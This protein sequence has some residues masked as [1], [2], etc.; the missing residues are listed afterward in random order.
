MSKIPVGQTIRFAYT[1]TFGE[2]GTIIGLIWIP[3]LINA[4]A[5]F[6]ALRAYYATLAD[7]FESGM[8]P[9]GAGLGLP[10]L[11][12]F[13]AMLMVAMIGVSITQQ[14][15]GLRQGPA[16]AHISLGSMEWRAFGG[17]FGLY[18]LFV[19]FI[20]IFALM[21]GATAAAS[22]TAVQSNPG[23]AAAAGVG[24]V[25]AVALGICLVAYMVVRL[26]FLLVPSVVDG[27]EF[28]LT[29]SW[30]LTH[31]NF[32]RIVAVALATLLPIFLIFAA[33]EMIILGPGFFIPDVKHAG[34]TAAALRNMV[35]QMRAMQ[36]NMPLLMGLSF[37]VSP[38]LYGLMFSASAF[39]YRSLSGSHP[40]AARSAN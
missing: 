24:V 21:V 16:F 29:R 3:T 18:L 35:S 1:F 12:A 17:F 6:F 28:G 26:S 23:W 32:W 14:A 5:T 2:I 27:G 13:L 33:I 30:Q 4:V 19:L 39:A 10:V 20:V 36:D 11:V 38:L 34:D 8:P 7:S 31:G 40:Q 22:A 25:I 15:L 9:A 37:V